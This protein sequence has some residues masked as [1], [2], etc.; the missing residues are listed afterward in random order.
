M[1]VAALLVWGTGGQ[2]MIQSDV[3]NFL[4]NAKRLKVGQTFSVY[5]RHEVVWLNL[6]LLGCLATCLFLRDVSQGC[7]M[8]S[9]SFVWE[10]GC[11][12]ALAGSRGQCPPVG[13]QPASQPGFSGLSP[14]PATRTALVPPSYGAGDGQRCSHCHEWRC[15]E[16]LTENHRHSSGAA[17]T[18]ALL[19]TDMRRKQ[20]RYPGSFF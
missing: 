18:H 10:E 16:S 19:N 5:S 17:V 9:W 20:D 14:L 6:R 4:A 3:C 2:Q 7:R 1:S 8:E 11:N 15:S 12:W 13:S